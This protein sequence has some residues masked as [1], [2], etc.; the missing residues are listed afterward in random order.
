MMDGRLPD[1]RDAKIAELRAR[2]QLA[3]EQTRGNGFQDHG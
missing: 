2:A 3:P 1:A